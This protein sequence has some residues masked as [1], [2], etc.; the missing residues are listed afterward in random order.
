MNRKILVLLALV[1]V[2]VLSGQP[3]WSQALSTGSI[4]GTV[5]DPSGAVVSGASISITEP[6]DRSCAE[7]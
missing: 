4:Q 5:T 3:A 2:A 7:S 6:G 1:A